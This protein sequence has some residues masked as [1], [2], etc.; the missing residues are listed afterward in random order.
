MSITLP[1]SAPL[2]AFCLALSA[3]AVLLVSACNDSG[4]RPMAASESTT[5][6]PNASRVGHLSHAAHASEEKPVLLEIFAPGEGDRAGV[7]G[8]GWFVD[9][10]LEF[11]G[12][13]RSTGFIANQLTGPGVHNNAP[14]F[15]GVFAPGKDDRFGGL[16]VTFSTAAVG[17]KSCQ[18]T[19]NL[20]NITGPTN[21]AED[22]TEIWDT[23]II[24]AANFG[25]RTNSTL[26]AAEISDRNHDGVYN[27]APDVVPDSNGD[28]VCDDKDLA[29]LGTASDIL[30]I[31]FYIR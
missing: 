25:R 14:P 24:T 31:P 13:L 8:V 4:A 1:R 30:V 26:Y 28:G 3:S 18:N 29:A 2:G 19:A 15:A 5:R 12:N 27:D 11:P 17:A 23:W 22:G 10:D 16:V 9:L 20:F 6:A 21:I 7:D